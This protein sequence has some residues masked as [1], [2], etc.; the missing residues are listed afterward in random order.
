MHLYRLI[1]Q[2]MWERIYD[3]VEILTSCEEFDE[4]GLRNRLKETAV[5]AI[6]FKDLVYNNND[7]ETQ[8]FLD[9]KD[10]DMVHIDLAIEMSKLI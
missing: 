6:M 10:Y 8:M 5:V 1:Y 2:E 4:E 3:A 7:L 9:D